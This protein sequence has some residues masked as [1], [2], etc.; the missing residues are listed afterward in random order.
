MTLR[1]EFTMRHSDLE[2]FLSEPVW[3]EK[4]GCML[5]ILSAFARLG[6]DPWQEAARLAAMPRD[7]AAAALAKLL[8]SLPWPSPEEPDHGEIARTLVAVLP[9]PAATRATEAKGQ[10]KPARGWSILEVILMV[11]LAGVLVLLQVTGQ[12]F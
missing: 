7:A 1:A 10:V 8:S 11:A 12:L 4:N 2:G 9:K 3:E 5:S 6:V